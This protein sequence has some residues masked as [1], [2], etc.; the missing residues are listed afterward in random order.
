[1]GFV[2]SK[3]DTDIWMRRNGDIWEYIATYV[4]NLAIIMKDPKS[5]TDLLIDKYKYKL[6]GVGPIT[7]HLGSDYK[8]DPDMTFYVSTKSYI[9]KMIESYERTFGAKR[10][11]LHWLE[12]TAQ[13]WTTWSCLGLPRSLSSNRILVPFNGAVSYERTFGAKPQGNPTPLDG[14]D[15]PEMDDSKLLGPTEITLFQLHIGS[16]QWCVI[17]GR[18]DT[19]TAVMTMSRYRAAPC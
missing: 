4:D 19:A 6:K 12:R 7:Y 18:F 1:M 2:P 10:I 11:Q 3:A 8:R 14:N 13:R 17:I 15:H 9:D 5:F 16:L